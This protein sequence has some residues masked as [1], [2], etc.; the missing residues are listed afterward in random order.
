MTRPDGQQRYAQHD[1]YLLE[2][3]SQPVRLSEFRF[4]QLDSLNVVGH[5]VIFSAVGSPPDNPVIPQEEP[6]AKPSSNIFMLEFDPGNR[7]IQ[8]PT[9]M[10]KPMSITLTGGYSTKPAVSAD[11]QGIAFRNLS[12]VAGRNRYNLA[13]GALRGTVQKYVEASG[14]GFSRPAFVGKIVLA[15]ELSDDRYEIHVFD[16]ARDSSQVIAVLEHSSHSLKSLERIE[17]VLDK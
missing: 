15:N 17:I 12:P 14:I 8:A 16:V 2:G 7:R 11:E 10:L 13:I 3:S 6:S 5:N 9:R 4:Y 1:F